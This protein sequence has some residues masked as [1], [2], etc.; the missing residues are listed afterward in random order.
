KER[1]AFR[2]SWPTAMVMRT[3]DPPRETHIRIRGQYDQLGEKVEPGV[4]EQLFEWSQDL[5]RNRLGLARW[6]MDPRHPLTA[7]VVVNRYWQRYFGTGLVKTSEDFGAQGEWPSHPELLDWLATEFI[8]TGWD[9]KAMQRLIVTSATYR[10]D[11]VTRPEHMELDPENRLL[12]RAPRF[13]L[14]AENI[15]DLAMA[16]S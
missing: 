12:A 11:S 6:L 8:R 4:P 1:D 13:R 16:A 3:A 5:P 2:D 10:Q 14:D 9:I 7:R 15:R